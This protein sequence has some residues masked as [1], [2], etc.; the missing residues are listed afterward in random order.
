MSKPKTDEEAIKLI[1]TAVDRGMTFMDN[2][3]DYA[4]G[5]SE[6]RMGKVLK[7]GY[8]QKV[9]L[10]SKIDGRDKNRRQNRLTNRFCVC[11]PTALT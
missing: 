10:M 7:D 11:K 1:R 3:W 2:C 6:I 4:D 9:F 8:R 5:L